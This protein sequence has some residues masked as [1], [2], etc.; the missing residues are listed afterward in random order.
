M[1]A[2]EL[3]QEISEVVFNIMEKRNVIEYND[4]GLHKEI[5]KLIMPLIDQFK[6]DVCKKQRE[7]CANIRNDNPLSCK[8]FKSGVYIYTEDI[9]NVPEPD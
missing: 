9:L 8:Y 1:K 6:K 3:K 7:I 4:G 2:I 5:R